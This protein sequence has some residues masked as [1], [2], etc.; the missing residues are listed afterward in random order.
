MCGGKTWKQKWCGELCLNYI[1][2]WY[3]NTIGWVSH[4]EHQ[5]F[6]FYEKETEETSLFCINKKLWNVYFRIQK[7][8]AHHAL[9]INFIQ[10]MSLA[11]QWSLSLDNQYISVFQSS[12]LLLFIR[13]WIVL[14]RDPHSCLREVFIPER[15]YRVI[16]IPSRGDILVLPTRS[17]GLEECH[18]D[19]TSTNQGH[20]LRLNDICWLQFVLSLSS[21]W[22]RLLC[23]SKTGIRKI[24]P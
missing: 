5:P 17:G 20:P 9:N 24:R 7:D 14:Y 4:K 11:V 3:L 1:L 6:W 12:R 21:S 22:L 23:W 10:G 18:Q 16:C 13:R 15:S 19:G 8:N 2:T